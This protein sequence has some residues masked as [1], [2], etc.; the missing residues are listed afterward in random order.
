MVI[1][2]GCRCCPSKCPTGTPDYIDIDM[3][4]VSDKSLYTMDLEETRVTTGQ[5]DRV[6]RLKVTLR[7]ETFPRTTFRLLRDAA[8][9]EFVYRFPSG[10]ELRLNSIFGPSGIAPG[11]SL[12]SSYA[13]GA[14]VFRDTRV[15]NLAVACRNQIDNPFNPGKDVRS[16]SASIKSSVAGNE[17]EHLHNGFRDRNFIG[18]D[19]S[20]GGGIPDGTRAYALN[21]ARSLSDG[22]VIEDALIY[23]TK[24]D[25]FPHRMKC[26][27]GLSANTDYSTTGT[28]VTGPS[29]SVYTYK[30]T[31]DFPLTKNNSVGVLNPSR[32]PVVWL[33][34]VVD[35][36]LF[37]VILG[38]PDGDVSIIPSSDFLPLNVNAEYYGVLSGTARDEVVFPY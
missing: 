16:Y 4:A 13:V 8:T 27:V 28:S 3:T 26:K 31:H 14:A 17:P 15:F 2:P 24:G 23:E 20:I 9:G 21:W 10:N 25:V 1:F 11:I 34:A 22:R 36:T 38:I 5:A 35:C 7:V 33:G 32:V 18:S 12:T 37:D 30:M 29:S 19:P 6:S